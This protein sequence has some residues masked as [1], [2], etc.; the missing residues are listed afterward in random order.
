M[1]PATHPRH[2]LL[3][4]TLNTPYYMRPHHTEQSLLLSMPRQLKRCF[5]DGVENTNAWDRNDPSLQMAIRQLLDF[6]GSCLCEEARRLFLPMQNGEP[7]QEMLLPGHR[8]LVTPLGLIPT[9][10][11][12]M[13]VDPQLVIATKHMHFHSDGYLTIA[14]GKQDKPSGGWILEK[15]H[16]IVLWALYGPPPE[17]LA[18]PCVMHICHVPDC[19]NVDHLCWGEDAENKL[20]KEAATAAAR[21]RLIQQGRVPL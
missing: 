10:Q 12:C 16:R 15:A 3:G 9:L 8:A 7:G 20:S 18:Q 11:L 13:R 4:P 21:N 5:N 1:Q 19:L 6:I 17:D 2:T 14:V